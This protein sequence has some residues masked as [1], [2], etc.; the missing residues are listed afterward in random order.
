MAL[1]VDV[2]PAFEVCKV[3]SIYLSIYLCIYLSIYVYLSIYRSIY[4]HAHHTTY[5]ILY[6]AEQQGIARATAWNVQAVSAVSEILTLR[7]HVPKYHILWT[8]CI[9]IGTTLGPMYILYEYMDPQG[10]PNL[11]GC[12][13]LEQPVLLLSRCLSTLVDAGFST[14]CS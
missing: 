10:K 4:T 7:V 5:C 1:G 13:F 6:T 9:Y 14:M 2:T 3:L 8:Q 12:C 11:L